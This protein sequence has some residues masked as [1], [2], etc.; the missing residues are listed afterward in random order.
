MDCYSNV[1]VGDFGFARV[2]APQEK[3][4]THCGSRAYVAVELLRGKTYTGNAA[5]IWSSGVILFIM[6]TG[7]FTLNFINY[8]YNLNMN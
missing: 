6:L 5:D 3:S 8:I 7:I 1:K 2:L 4:N